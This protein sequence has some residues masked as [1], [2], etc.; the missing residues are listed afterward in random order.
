MWKRFLIG[1][2]YHATYPYRWPRGR[3]DRSRGMA[4]VMILFY[5]RIADDRANSWTCGHAM[6]ERQIRWLKRRFDMIGL[7]EAQ[8]R[9]RSGDNR[10]PA[11]SVTFDDGYAENCRRALPF[12]ISERVPCTYFVTT[13]YVF[14]GVP[15]PHDLAR[16]DHFRPNTIDELRR[17]AAD[18]IEIG[19]HSQTHADLGKCVDP[20]RLRSE[21]VS[22]GEELQ[23]ALGRPVRYFAFPF[24]L[25]ANL[26]RDAFQMAYEHGYEAVLSAY[27]AYNYPGGDAFHLKRIHG[28]DDMVRLKNWTSGDPRRRRVPNFEFTESGAQVEPSE[29]PS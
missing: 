15:F 25:P 21:V 1:L 8:D 3:L 12:L 26:N 11:V 14:D 16:G 23:A 27:G 24:G 17:M 22:S 19:A 6:F 18:G 29:T 10:R 7:S 20:A 5:H 28:G 9:I 13:R 4:P 2:Y